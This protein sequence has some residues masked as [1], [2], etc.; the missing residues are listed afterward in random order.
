MS[1]AASGEVYRVDW[2]PG[3]DLLHGTCH[4]GTEHT[5]QDPVEMW[6][7]MLAHP[8]HPGHPAV[9]EAHEAHEVR[10]RGA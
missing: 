10:G 6:E 3:T 8:E 2:V 9:H 1:A 4:C 5:A 7:W